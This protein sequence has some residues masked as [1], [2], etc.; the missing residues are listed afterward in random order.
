MTWC[1]RQRLG[2]IFGLAGN[3]VCCAGSAISPR[4]RHSVGSTA[5]PIRSAATANCTTRRPARRSSAASSPA[6]SPAPRVPTAA[7]SSP[8]S[9]A[10]PRRSTRRFTAPGDRPRQEDPYLPLSRGHLGEAVA[11][12][13]QRRRFGEGGESRLRYAPTCAREKEADRRLTKARTPC[14]H[15]LPC[16]KVISATMATQKPLMGTARRTARRSAPQAVSDNEIPALLDRYRCPVPFH[17]VRTRFLGSIASPGLSV[18]PLDTVKAL[19]AA[20]S[21]SSTASM[22]STNGWPCWSWGCGTSLVATRTGVSPSDCCVLT[23][24]LKDSR[25]SLSFGARSWTEH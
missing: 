13:P 8:I 2:Y 4:M 22:R 6:S 15:V 20:N 25:G 19:W 5:R 12:A 23:R 21:R 18:A 7:S 11:A 1:E 14:R 16:R 9:P 3:A 10:C 17:A 24:P